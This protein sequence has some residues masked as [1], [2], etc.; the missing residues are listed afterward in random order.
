MTGMPLVDSLIRE[1]NAT[2]FMPNR[3]RMIV[4][5]YLTFDLKQDWRFGAYHFEEN[6]IDHDVQ[7]NFGGWSQCAGIAGRFFAF[8]CLVQSNKFDK[9]GK[10]IKLWCPELKDVP[11]A[12]IHAP[13]DM[14]KE[15]KKKLKIE[16]GEKP[17]DE[18]LSFY[19]A[20]VVC[21]KYT[22]PEAQIK[23]AKEFKTVRAAYNAGVS[24]L[25]FPKVSK[26]KAKVS[27]ETENES[28]DS[29][30]TL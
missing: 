9:E 2:G 26:K 15:L 8:N 5:S 18:A 4:A 30:E 22:G 14:P 19:P 27:K 13:W 29:E 1:M 25:G 7:S 17:T 3:G 6:L 21:T 12:Y 11:S 10:Y 23:R 16:I 20:P 28:F 24:P